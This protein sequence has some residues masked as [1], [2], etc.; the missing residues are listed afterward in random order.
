MLCARCVKL[1]AVKVSGYTE[2]VRQALTVV[3]FPPKFRA[4]YRGE[5]L[6]QYPH[7]CFL[8]YDVQLLEPLAHGSR[9][10]MVRL[11][12]PAPARPMLLRRSPIIPITSKEHNLILVSLQQVVLFG[13]SC[14][15]VGQERVEVGFVG[16]GH[17][18]C[19]Q[20]ED[21][22]SFSGRYRRTVENGSRGLGHI[23]VVVGALTWWRH[24]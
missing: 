21:G 1:E 2:P 17:G 3:D 18:S 12:E 8:V 10:N 23:G 14:E 16:V 4:H 11:Q 19:I 7:P 5:Y 6:S 24:S 20:D 15:H 13:Q 9:Q 22:P